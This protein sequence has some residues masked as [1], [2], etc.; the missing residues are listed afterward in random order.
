MRLFNFVLLFLLMSS[1]AFAGWQEEFEQDY[2]NSG[3]D[4]AVVNALSEGATPDQIIKTALPLEGLTKENLVKALFCS[5]SQTET[6]RKASVS[7]GISEGTVNEGYQLALQEC[8]RQMDENLN[9]A[10]DSS[11]RFPGSKSSSGEEKNTNY[12]SPWKFE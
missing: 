5:L 7:N 6:I 12:A 1:T 8:P 10:L 11:S 2:R 4:S 9:S 3:I